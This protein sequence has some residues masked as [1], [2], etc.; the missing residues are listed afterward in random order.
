MNKAGSAAA[1]RSARIIAIL[2]AGTAIMSFAGIEHA[3]AQ[4]ATAASAVASVNIPAQPLSDALIAFSRQTRVETFVTSSL[5]AGKTSN[6]VNGSMAPEAA[7]RQLLAGTGLTYTFTNPS[8]I[9]IVGQ[10]TAGAEGGTVSADGSTVL[11]TITVQ[12]Q[13]ATTEGSG[14]Y[15]TGSMS[16]A[17]PLNLSIRETP[18]SVSVVT[19]DRMADSGATTLQDALSYTTGISVDTSGPQRDAYT[20]RSFGVSNIMLD[21]LVFDYEMD[22]FAPTGLAMYDRVE[23]VRGATGL[24]E[25]AGNPSASINLVRKRPTDTFQG[26]VTTSAGSWDNYL[27]TLDLS[28]P[29]NEAKTLRGRIVTSLN[30]SDTFQSG[31]G[32]ERQLFYG[33]LEADLTENT[34]FTVGG[35]YNKDKNPGAEYYGLPTKADGTFYDFDR[36]VRA[37]P[38]WAHFNKENTS[39]FAELDH[40]FDN[41]WKLSLKGAYLE[42]KTDILGAILWARDSSDTFGYITRNYR[43]DWK[44]TSLDARANGPVEFLGREHEL[45]FGANYR[46]RHH[47]YSGGSSPDGTYTYRFDPTNWQ[48]SV[49]IPEPESW[50]LGTAG[51]YYDDLTTEQYGAFATAKINITDPLNVFIGGRVSWYDYEDYMQSGTWSENVSYRAS[52]ELTPYA[53]VTYDIGN[54]HTVYGSF[55]RIFMPQNYVSAGG[56]LLDPIEGTNY[57]L[58]VKG[59]YLDGRLNASLALFQINQSNLPDQLPASSCPNLSVSCYAAAGEVRSRGIELEVSG[60][61]TDDWRVFAGYTYVDSKYVEDSTAGSAGDPYGLTKPKHLLTLSTL[62][63]FSG[64]FEGWR[65]G[66]SARFQSETENTRSGYATVRQPGYGVVN[67]VAGYSPNENLDFQL[68]VN[69]VFDKYYYRAVGS[70]IGGNILGE[71]RSFVLTAKYKF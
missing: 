29:L 37:S 41:E 34:T 55:T 67:L 59:E 65:V 12:G 45:A 31:T 46:H 39:V 19:S 42:G 10:G 69:N 62:Y 8:T 44:S 3:R 13:G 9:R 5:A 58:G 48:D 7:L 52:A 38:S 25:G 30:D 17:T 22:S 61:I 28:G 60:K 49:N 47:I 54:N 36:S 18:Q 14:S 53:A 71:P 32:R 20:A 56:G 27:G 35:Y 1:E 2:M 24:M 4:S 66:A 68:N 64:Q 16:T 51:G 43:M 11:E 6:P 50:T 21:G 15:T 63:T 57:E 70:P 26:E 40:S 33:I 23:V